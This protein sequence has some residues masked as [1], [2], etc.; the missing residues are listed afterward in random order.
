MSVQVEE[1]DFAIKGASPRKRGGEP[2]EV[3]A[4]AQEIVDAAACTRESRV[5]T[6][7]KR[8]DYTED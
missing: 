7:S 5:L 6:C 2:D 8:Q 1:F 4:V 3:R